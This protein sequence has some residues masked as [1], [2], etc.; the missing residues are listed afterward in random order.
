[1]KIIVNTAHLYSSIIAQSNN[2]ENQ[3]EDEEI[4]AENY[5]ETDSRRGEFNFG[6]GD[7]INDSVYESEELKAHIEAKFKVCTSR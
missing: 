2:K 5:D 1:M 4:I 3:R 7:E 6:D